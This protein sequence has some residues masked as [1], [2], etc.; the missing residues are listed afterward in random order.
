MSKRLGRDHF[1]TLCKER[2]HVLVSFDGYTGV[3]SILSFR[4]NTCGHEWSSTAHSYKNSKTGC[5][6]CKK[7]TISNMTLTREFTVAG[8]RKISLTRKSNP[9]WNKGV[10]GSVPGNSEASYYPTPE[11]R[12]LPGTLYLVRYL[13]DSGTHFK[14][15]ITRRT[16][17]QRFRSGG[18]ISIIHLHKSTLGECFDL[19]QSLLKWAKDN[20]HRYSSPTTTELIHPNGL[21]YLLGRLT[22]LC[23]S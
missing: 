5:W 2:N 9:P 10:K 8:R 6:G 21:P 13:D 14:L 17:S 19:E 3:Q 22:A 18:L 12:I 4:C 15:G 1:E 11:Q 23:L 20:G 16:L 7:K